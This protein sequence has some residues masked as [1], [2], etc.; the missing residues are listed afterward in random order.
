M[1][2]PLHSPPID[3]PAIIYEITSALAFYLLPCAFLLICLIIN[4]NSIKKPPYF[5]VFCIFGSMGALCLTIYFS[6]GPISILGFLI[7]F[8]I[9]PFFLVWNWFKLR[10]AARE[11]IAH[12]L[13][14][15]VSIIPIAIL[16]FF[17][18]GNFQ[19]QERELVVSSNC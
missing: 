17:T 12:R 18:V 16:I 7:T 10:I 15:W 1:V 9:S 19:I 6:N 4:L 3:T 14:Q 2:N 5:S 8:I 13:V 11:S